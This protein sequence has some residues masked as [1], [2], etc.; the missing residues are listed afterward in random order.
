MT[1]PFTQHS[2]EAGDIHVERAARLPA[3]LDFGGDPIAG[4]LLLKG[5]SVIRNLRSTLDAETA[6]AGWTFFF[7]AGKI[8]GTWFGVDRQKTLG[9]ALGRLARHVKSERCNSFEII[10]VTSKHFLGVFRVSVAAHA[11]H[12]QEVKES[13]VCFGQ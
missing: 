7:M 10:Q 2:M 8:E 3:F 6:K 13:L 5:W 1:V 11:R 9:A 4:G 12:L